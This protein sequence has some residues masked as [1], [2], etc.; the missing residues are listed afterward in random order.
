MRNYIKCTAA[1]ISSLFIMA[2]QN[3]AGTDFDNGKDD[4]PPQQKAEYTVRFDNNCPSRNG[5]VWYFCSESAPASITVKEG[6]YVNLPGFNG[7]LEKIVGSDSEGVYAFEKWNTAA[8]GKGDSYI[9]GASYQVNDNVTFYAVYSTE[10][11]P[12]GN[13]E[14][15][16]DSVLDFSVTSTYSMKV[17]ET[18]EVPSWIGDYSVYYE[19]YSGS[20]VIELGSGSLKAIGPG[21]ATVNAIDWDNPSRKWT[22]R[23][24][25]TADGFNGS[26][27]DYKLVGRWED[28][29]SYVVFNAD[30]TGD[31]KVY[32]NGN[33]LQESTFTWRAFENTYGKFLILSNCSESYLEG[34]QF[35]ITSISATSLSLHGYFAFLAPEDTSWTKR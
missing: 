31:L 29:N 22:C 5:T 11:N 2:C 15:P 8:D 30:N 23:I 21:S 17:G 7:E 12:E 25:V 18:V 28:G 16:E 33:L 32:K 9:A 19:V 20:D 13:D 6:E 34:K 10:K 27:L 24:T 26:A 35:T 1:I 4:T 3:P 14:D